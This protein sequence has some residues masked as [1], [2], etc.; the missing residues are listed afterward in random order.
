MTLSLGWPH[1]FSGLKLYEKVSK[2]TSNTEVRTKWL[3]SYRQHLQKCILFIL[4]QEKFHIHGFM[5]ER[6]NSIA[7]ALE[8]HLSCTNP[9][10]FWSKFD[11]SLFLRH[12]LT[13]SMHGFRSWF[14][15][16]LALSHYLKQ[17]WSS[18]MK[19]YG[20]VR[21]QWVNSLRPNGAIGLGQHWLM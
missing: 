18:F 19:S 1:L 15:L 16:E 10:I 7:N 4:L 5:H 20:V 9:L 14:D 3:P 17:C 8:L 2:R 12:Q 13:I 21:L 6:C 11:R